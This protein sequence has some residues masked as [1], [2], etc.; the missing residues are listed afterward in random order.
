MTTNCTPHDYSD[1]IDTDCGQALSDL[2]T[3]I[4]I[5]A[6]HY[7][8]LNEALSTNTSY[9]ENNIKPLEDMFKGLRLDLALVRGNI[10]IKN[11]AKEDV[12]PG[13]WNAIET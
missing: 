5:A 11:I 13:I 1:I 7:V 8:V 10:G 3:R 9:I 4:D 2:D 12:P 6:E